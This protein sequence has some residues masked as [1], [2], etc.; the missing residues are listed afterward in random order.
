MPWLTRLKLW[1]LGYYTSRLSNSSQLL[2][3]KRV[4][5]AHLGTQPRFVLARCLV[6]E[7]FL[8][9]ADFHRIYKL[10]GKNL[11]IDD[12]FSWGKHA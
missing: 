10:K 1:R 2:A 6:L 5:D 11:F 7:R 9:C 3:D 12:D 8:D 4:D